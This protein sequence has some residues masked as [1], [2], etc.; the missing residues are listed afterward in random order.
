MLKTFAGAVSG[1]APQT[2]GNSISYGFRSGLRVFNFH[3]TASVLTPRTLQG[4]QHSQAQPVSSVGSATQLGRDR[5][6]HEG[7][8]HSHTPPFLDI[9]QFW[10]FSTTSATI[11]S[12]RI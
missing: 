5:V 7:C 1:M 9:Q 12:I 11:Y 8:Q 10:G 2:P 6:W 3:S 4:E